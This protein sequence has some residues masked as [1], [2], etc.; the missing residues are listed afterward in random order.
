MIVGG[1]IGV[2]W[3]VVIKRIEAHRAV[4]SFLDG[5]EVAIPLKYLPLQC[6]VGDVLKVEIHFKPFET[7]ERLLKET[8]SV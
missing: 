4:V 5:E 1:G 6:R 7:L 3:D 2:Q 8:E